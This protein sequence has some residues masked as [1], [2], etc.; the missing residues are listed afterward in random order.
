[1]LQESDLQ[2]PGSRKPGQVGKPHLPEA[3]RREIGEATHIQPAV[4]NHAQ[5]KCATRQDS[6]D[7]RLGL[8]SRAG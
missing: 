2:V 5:Y 3:S 6:Y 8:P 7:L 1:M 4:G